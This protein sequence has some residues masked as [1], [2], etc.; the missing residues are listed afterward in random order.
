MTKHAEDSFGVLS[1]AS[2]YPGYNGVNSFVENLTEY[3]QNPRFARWNPE[4]PQG[5]DLE[6]DIERTI[7]WGRDY[8]PQFGYSTMINGKY[9]VG[10]FTRAVD[11]PPSLDD[12]VGYVDGLNGFVVEGDRV[13]ASPEQR[14]YNNPEANLLIDYLTHRESRWQTETTIG[15]IQD[16]EVDTLEEVIDGILPHMVLHFNELNPNRPLDDSVV[17]RS[18]DAATRISNSPYFLPVCRIPKRDR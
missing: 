13:L 15:V 7:T 1:E 18:I 2:S 12:F 10:P 8:V 17:Q 5:A 9:L 14:W 3:R 11:Q 4:D 16:E 6:F